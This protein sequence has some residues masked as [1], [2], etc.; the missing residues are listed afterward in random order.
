M[1]SCLYEVIPGIDGQWCVRQRNA[2]GI[3]RSFA[4]KHAAEE[5]L[6]QIAVTKVDKSPV[7]LDIATKEEITPSKHND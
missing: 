1:K 2:R 6:H 3:M 5:Y 4:T 7:T